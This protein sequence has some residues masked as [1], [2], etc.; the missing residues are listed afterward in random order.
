MKKILFLLIVVSLSSCAINTSFNSLFL[1]LGGIILFITLLL[2]PASAEKSIIRPNSEIRSLLDN[3]SWES[4]PK[5]L[6]NESPTNA[7][8]SFEFN[9]DLSSQHRTLLH[10]S[11]KKVGSHWGSQ[12]T[13]RP[14]FPVAASSFQVVGTSFRW[15]TSSWAVEQ[16]FRWAASSSAAKPSFRWATSSWAAKPSFRLATSSSHLA[17]SSWATITSNY[18]TT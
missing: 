7:P 4:T 2:N 18:F 1:K 14:S 15:A 9:K 16:S 5:L 13:V 12:P 8:F 6:F 11:R 10:R 3:A 17:A